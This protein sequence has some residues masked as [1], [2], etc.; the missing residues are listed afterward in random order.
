MMLILQAYMLVLGVCARVPWSVTQE[1][2][3]SLL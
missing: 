3:D 2:V 1:M